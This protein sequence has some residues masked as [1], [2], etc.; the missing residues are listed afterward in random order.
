MEASKR[1]ASSPTLLPRT[2]NPDMLSFYTLGS[3]TS[4]LVFT[5]EREAGKSPLRSQHQLLGD[6]GMEPPPSFH[7]LLTQTTLVI[8][9]ALHHSSSRKGRVRSQTVNVFL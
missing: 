3:P 4:K 8:P 1:L 9:E 6:R 2:S 5:R 7:S